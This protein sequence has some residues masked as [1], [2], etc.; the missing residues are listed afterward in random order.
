MAD[1]YRPFTW[2][3]L[4]DVE[5]GRENLGLEMPVIVYRLFEYTTKDVLARRYGV[6]AAKEII[7]E[8]GHLA[9][10]HF[11]KNVLFEEGQSFDDFVARLQRSL[12]DFKIGVLRLE[13]VDLAKK[14]L[15]LV[16]SEDL[17]CSGM[18]VSDEAVCNYD[19]GFIAGILESF[20]GETW[21]VREIDC[22]ATGDRVCRF[23]AKG[24][25]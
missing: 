5:L 13:F 20:T 17:D 6:E 21:H 8:C 4:G 19:E 9:G 18:S 10:R 23:E 15:T 24:G 7:R 22:W 1:L 14:E 12:K 2:D 11:Y 16:V 25:K 3:D